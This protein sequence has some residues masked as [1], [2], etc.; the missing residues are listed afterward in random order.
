MG[1]QA[2][3]R[4]N[5]E[6]GVGG[7]VHVD[8]V[9]MPGAQTQVVTV[10]EEVPTIT[11]THAQLEGI[12]S[13]TALGDLPFSGHN[14]V[15]LL[16]LL[17]TFQLR[18]GAGAGPTAISSNGLPGD[19]NVYVLDGVAN[20]RPYLTTSGVN[21]GYSA[22]G[23]EQA[24]MM[25]T[26]AIQ[27][28]NVVANTKAEFGWRPGAQ[29]NIGIKSGTNS[30]HGSAFALGRSTGLMAQNPFF[31]TKSETAFENFGG[32][33]GGAV[34]KDKLFYLFGY[35]G[36]RYTVGNPKTSNVPT[37][38]SGLGTSNSL[39]DAINDLLAHGYCN[40]ATAGCTRPVSQLSLNL[41]GCVLTPSVQC[42]ADKGL[43][44]NNTQS[45]TFPVNFPTFGGNNNGVARADYHPN[46]RHSFNGWFWDGR[47]EAVAPVS[48]V[49]QA[50]WSSP[51]LVHSRIARLWWTWLPNSTWV[52]DLRFGWDYSHSYNSG[53][54][55]CD[56]SSGAPNY[57]S[58]GFVS[59]GTAC[60]FPGVTITGL[61]GNVLA[62]AGGL[63]QHGTT[64]RWVDT[65]SYSHGNHI[66]KFGGEFVRFHLHIDSN[67]A[68]GKGTLAFSTSTPS[69]NAFGANSLCP[70]PTCLA[71]T[72]TALEN[73]MAGTVNSGTI[74]TGVSPR[75]FTNHAFAFFA[76]DDWRIFPRLTL[77]LGLRYEYTLAINEVNGQIGNINLA[78]PS[79]ICQQEASGCTL[80]KLVPSDISPR[81]GLAWDVTGKGKTVLRTS[82]N[83]IYEQPWVQHFINSNATL[84]NM[85]TGLTFKNGSTV[86]TTPGGT[87]NL[88]SFGI[89]PP[90]SPIPW[91]VNTPVF[92]NYTSAA[93][94]CTNSVPCSIGG[95]SARLAYPMVLNWN[96]GI[97]HA[98][99]NNLTL[100]ADY[101]GN[102]GQH[103]FGTTDINR[104]SPGSSSKTEEQARRPYTLNGQFPWFAG[105]TV[106]G[107]RANWSNYNAL[108]V[109][110]R[111]RASH[112]L[113]FLATFT[114]AQALASADARDNSN[115]LSEYGTT[116]S[117]IRRRF[118]FG[119]SYLIPG[120]KGF[121]QMLEG[122]QI[123][124]TV[125]V[126]SK[127]PIN[128]TEATSTDLSGTGQA[129]GRWTL[130]GDPADFQLGGRTT[131]PCFG[132]VGSTFGKDAACTPVAVG[133][134]P[135][136]VTDPKAV[137]AAKIVNMPQAC[138]DGANS[139]IP[140]AAMVA[141]GNANAYGVQSLANM[142]CY[143]MGNAVI[144][145]PAQGT[146]GTMGLFQLRGR[147][148]S[149]W[150]MSIIKTWRLTEKVSTQF[151][152]E[153]YNVT[154]SVKFGDPSATL[155]SPSTFGQSQATPDVNA[156]SPIVGT[157]GPRKFQLGLKVLF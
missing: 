125:S 62:G 112:N 109:Q 96:F 76:Q 136:G 30:I 53:A 80:Y 85:P 69:L 77:N 145:P 86:V 23:P 135:S 146:F 152:T 129:G 67:T 33:F 35:E 6:I 42:T 111:Q 46:E 92:A 28:F 101:V 70:P 12:I 157:G 17:P 130:T 132:L 39:P 126:Y 64:S 18:P 24:V 155:T 50:Y 139:I 74:Q 94:S 103:L 89:N 147:G 141:A 29:L 66:F 88:A 59:G 1:F 105:M 51:L 31:T 61:T 27:E 21:A 16:A 3:E 84:Q 151:R 107:M 144:V 36:Q 115:P 148:F 140:N 9:L 127:R 25:P 44:S 117:D 81:L 138:I 48:S 43:F 121:A 14:Y 56:P 124:S 143:M 102:H 63:D 10:T 7:D 52:N 95:V 106:F 57:A 110:A 120:R 82:F 128:A 41:A 20:Q 37:T 32:I 154:N 150:D 133:T 118:T 40:P 75:E 134:V 5:I 97:Q 47:G 113:T 83:I 13:G 116:T 90:A 78:S 156:N 2:F 38:A 131:V 153:I 142:G 104:P 45:T 123:T 100:E 65:V 79:G 98:I 11:T 26:D 87:I 34:K 58:L 114:W 137:A 122:W 72:P 73:F 71:G 54:Y 49:T 68:G 108:Q 19:F 119:P 55:D 22:G 8:V 15:Q 60:G 99:T 93:G 4:Q 91:S 149:E